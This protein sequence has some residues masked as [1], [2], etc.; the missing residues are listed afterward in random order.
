M[1]SSMGAG[2]GH[3]YSY[4]ASFLPDASHDTRRLSQRHH[5]GAGC[6]RGF[7]SHQG[8]CFSVRGHLLILVDL[9]RARADP[10]P[11]F[12][13]RS[14]GDFH[15][16]LVCSPLWDVRLRLDGC[17]RHD[18]R[19]GL[20]GL[21]ALC[22]VQLLHRCRPPGLRRRISG[23][24]F[25]PRCLLRQLGRSIVFKFLR[26]DV[27]QAILFYKLL[28][29]LALFFTVMGVLNIVTGLFSEGAAKTPDALKVEERQACMLGCLNT[30][31]ESRRQR[32]D[33]HRCPRR[34]ALV[35]LARVLSRGDV[36]ALLPLQ[37]VLHLDELGL[38]SPTFRRPVGS[39]PSRK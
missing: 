28:L 33:R 27:D 7:A 17:V 35:R 32:R 16:D 4:L 29:V 10:P 36:C 21:H 24:H 25:A 15:R 30:Q 23:V 1:S 22:T 39:P 26:L 34:P 19:Y 6:I 14:G 12:R 37:L 31:V 3:I 18:R 20:W 2:R 13:Y 5:R 8:T 38:S 9:H 11:G